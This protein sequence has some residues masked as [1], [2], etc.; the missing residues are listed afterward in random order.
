M[1]NTQDMRRRLK[2]KK[3]LWGFV[4]NLYR[5]K[6]DRTGKHD[7]QRERG[8]LNRPAGRKEGNDNGSNDGTAD[9]ERDQQIEV[10]WKRKEKG[11]E[12]KGKEWRTDN[13]EGIDE[14]KIRSAELRIESCKRERK[15]EE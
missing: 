15:E 5:V 6:G 14:R 3:D 8:E 12:A 2:K 4:T 10:L 9:E 13:K 1:H 7:I 11:E